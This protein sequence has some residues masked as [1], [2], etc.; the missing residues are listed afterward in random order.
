[1]AFYVIELEASGLYCRSCA[2]GVTGH[3]GAYGAG[4]AQ[5][6]LL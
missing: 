5:G 6:Q 2:V 3:L 4:T 1:M